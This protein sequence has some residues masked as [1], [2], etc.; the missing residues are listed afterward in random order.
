MTRLHKLSPNAH[1]DPQDVVAAKLILRG[2]GHYEA[3]DWGIS[4][5]PDRNLFDAIKDFQA[6]N[7]LRVDGIINSDGETVQALAQRLQAMGRN[8]DTILAHINPAEA[9]L[10]D[11]VTDGGSVNPR[12]GLFEF[13]FDFDDGGVLHSTSEGECPGGRVVYHQ[14]VLEPAAARASP[15][16]LCRVIAQHAVPECAVV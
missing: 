12:T 9:A 7:E 11:R 15:S 8:G 1:A 4:E 5:Y 3:P 10:L 13:A 6:Q 14:A 16:A 2:L